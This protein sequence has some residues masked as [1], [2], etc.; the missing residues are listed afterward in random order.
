MKKESKDNTPFY[1]G[2]DGGG[3]KCKAVIVDV[4]GKVLGTGISG[5]ANPLHGY[6]QAINSIVDSA[7]QALLDAALPIQKISQL[8]AGVGL[9]GVNL[10]SLFNMMA[11]WQHP[12]A[13]MY[14]T[15]DL[16]IACLGAHNGNDGAIVIAGTGSCGYSRIKGS[17]NIVGAHGFPQGD[18]GSGAWLGLQ[19][20]KR[21]L[22]SLDGFEQT[23]QMNNIMLQ[24]LNCRNALELVEAV[25]KQPASF[26]A[27]QAFVVFQ[28]ARNK[29]PLALDI[30][31]DGAHY[32][33]NVT[34]RLLLDQPPAISLIGGLASKLT[35]WLDQDVRL[36][37]RP[38]EQ[39][40]EIGAVIYAK[41]KTK[42]K[43]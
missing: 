5:P 2:I 10:P 21:V 11:Q 38:P 1:L 6:E 29:D 14:L 23:S 13:N 4:S 24:Q 16:H 26:F 35:D 7:K 17:T 37:L 8:V 22:L 33:S 27:R 41:Q 12:F 25:A 9:A 40:P 28:A 34:R 15:T 20:V 36:S 18:K 43:K 39:L 30:I 3:S 42:N 19:A 32:I 31:R